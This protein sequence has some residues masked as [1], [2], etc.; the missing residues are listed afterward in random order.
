MT[1]D[2][3]IYALQL[4]KILGIFQPIVKIVTHF[5]TTCTFMTSKMYY[6]SPEI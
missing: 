6:E 3:K 4:K 5:R 2:I 1:F